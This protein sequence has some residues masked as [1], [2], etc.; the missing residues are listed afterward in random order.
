LGTRLAASYG[1]TDFRALTPVHVF[2]TQ[3]VNQEIGWNLNIRQPLPGFPGLP[4]RIEAVADMR[5][6]LAQ[7]YLPVTAGSQTGL[8]V[9]SPR[10]VRG[11]LNFIF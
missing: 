11:G 2:M 4:G 3:N 8:L 7:G 9:N 1:W 10:A 6:L 5:N